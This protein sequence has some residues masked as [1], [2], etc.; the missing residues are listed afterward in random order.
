MVKDRKINHPA[1]VHQTFFGAILLT[2]GD[3]K[4]S[5]TNNVR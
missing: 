5:Y 1:Y 3:Y 4:Y 2:P